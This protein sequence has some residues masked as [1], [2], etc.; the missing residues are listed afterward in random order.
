MRIQNALYLEKEG[1]L[2][3]TKKKERTYYPTILDLYTEALK[4]I[5]GIANQTVLKDRLSE[6]IKNEQ[7]DFYAKS[8]KLRF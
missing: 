1:D 6:K 5:K 2:L 8:M 7:K 4:E 3:T